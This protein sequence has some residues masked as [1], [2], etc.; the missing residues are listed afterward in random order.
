[1]PAGSTAW[2]AGPSGSLGSGESFTVADTSYGVNDLQVRQTD[3]AGNSTTE[4]YNSN[5]TVDTTTPTLTAASI[6][7][8]TVTLTYSE[9]LDSAEANLPGVSA[10][11][12]TAN[13]A[14]KRRNKRRG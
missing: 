10:F 11:A 12:L 3:A 7:G 6:D 8:S 2:T 4:T 13:G 9:E 1:M 5:V 14:A